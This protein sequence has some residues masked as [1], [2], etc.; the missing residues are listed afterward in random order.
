MYGCNMMSETELTDSETVE[1]IE[2]YDEVREELDGREVTLVYDSPRSDSHMEITGGLSVRGE[3]EFSVVGDETRN[4]WYGRVNSAAGNQPRVGQFV[5]LEV[6]APEDSA[7]DSLNSAKESLENDE[8][9]AVAHLE[10]ADSLM[11]DCGV[12]HHA[13]ARS[14]V[15]TA[16]MI[17]SES[18]NTGMALVHVKNAISAFEGEDSEDPEVRTD[19]GEDMSVDEL[20]SER[21]SHITGYAMDQSA[22]NRSRHSQRVHEL[23]T[24]L[25][26]MG[27]EYAP[28]DEIMAWANGDR[29]EPPE[30]S[31]DDAATDGGTDTED[32]PATDALRRKLAESSDE[33]PDD[34]VDISDEDVFQRARTDMTDG[35]GELIIRF[36]GS[37]SGGS[38]S[39][40]PSNDSLFRDY[41][42]P[43]QI[44]ME[45]YGLTEGVSAAL[46]TLGDAVDSRTVPQGRIGVFYVDEDS[47]RVSGVK[48]TEFCFQ[49]SEGVDSDALEQELV[50]AANS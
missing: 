19:G 37:H 6:H 18:G 33:Y 23:E 20:R 34:P 9:S 25:D 39:V 29:E 48:L 42:S 8:S 36:C 11:E 47:G 12:S 22:E 4:V 49:Y 7:M 3:A 26:R 2:Q 31:D 1:T 15:D 5:R 17:L 44:L 46:D 32:T 35:S 50:Q 27:V 24:E 13:D 40:E 38:V 16:L 14:E 43:T 28:A 30:P 41:Y 21:R 10:T 45:H